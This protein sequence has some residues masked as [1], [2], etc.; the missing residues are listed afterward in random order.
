MKHVADEIMEKVGELPDL[1][2]L[3]V[4]DEILTQLDK[5]PDPEPDRIWAD[6]A[7]RRWE[8]CRSGLLKT[9]SY[10][11]IMKPHGRS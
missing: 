10:E 2:K 8:G 5:R 1:E 7:L 9:V 4:V 3:R 6:E 11:E